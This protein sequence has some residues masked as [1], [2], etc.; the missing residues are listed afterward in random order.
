MMSV[1]Q[2]GRGL[3]ERAH[4]HPAPW[5][6]MMM[7][8]QGMAIWRKVEEMQRYGHIEPSLSSTRRTGECIGRKTG[9][10]IGRRTNRNRNR[11]RN[12]NKR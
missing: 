12:Q 4:H 1:Q 5:M 3:L 9:E 10:C 6:M 7:I 2:Y 11:N 8:S